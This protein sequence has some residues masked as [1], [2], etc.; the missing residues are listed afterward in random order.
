M[1]AACGTV[2]VCERA[3]VCV[4]VCI[5]RRGVTLAPKLG[6]YLISTDS[7]EDEMRSD[8]MGSHQPCQKT[9]TAAK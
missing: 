6:C 5:D 8:C 9:R 2:C 1:G 3:C 7:R 4:S